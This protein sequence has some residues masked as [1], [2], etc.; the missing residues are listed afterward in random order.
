MFSF[1]SLFSKQETDKN[2]LDTSGCSEISI[3]PSLSNINELDTSGCS[4]MS[5][6][7][8]LPPCPSPLP[9]YEGPDFKDVVYRIGKLFKLIE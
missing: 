3:I 4:E 6:I 9:D 8:P 5:I 2:E 7:P 1:K